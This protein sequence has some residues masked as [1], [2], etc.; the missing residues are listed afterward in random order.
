MP[1][2][3][4]SDLGRP[5]P[6]SPHAVS[7]CLP[8]WADNIGYE[9]GEPRV[10]DKLTTGYP[11]FVYNQFCRDLFSRTGE[12]TCDPGEQCLV[13]PTAAAAER[14]ATFL[15]RHAG[16]G[17]LRTL[18]LQE[19]CPGVPGHDDVHV[20]VF[21]A[22]HARVAQDAWQHIGEG[23]SSRQA[24]D[25]LAGRPADDGRQAIQT[26]LARVG[27]LAGVPET[28]VRLA[29]SGMG[30]FAAVH[31]ALDRLAPGADSVQFGFPYVDALKV[32]QLC[33]SA[34]NLFLPEGNAT[35]LDQL[36]SALESGRRFCGV[37]TEFPS[38]P[39]LAVPDLE[40]LAGLCRTHGI[41]LVVDET[42]SGFGN[43]DVLSATDVV[44][45][46]LTKSFSGIGDVT[47]GSS[48]VNPASPFAAALVGALAESPSPEPYA[49]DAIV[50]EHN[51]RDYTD[52]FPLANKNA[53][54]LVDFLRAEPGVDCVYYPDDENPSGDGLHTKRYD[55]FRRPGGGCG[56]LL[57]ILLE[58]P[59][60]TAP[61]FY[62][63]LAVD[64]GPNLGTNYTLAC[65]FTILAHYHE[66]AFAESCGVSRY[67]IRVSVGLEPV[68]DLIE[69][70][71]KA[72]Q[73][74]CR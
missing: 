4:P 64:K 57:S 66:L 34:D 56:P 28:H 9:E 18:P 7:A 49:T 12:T 8:T 13:F 36:Q 47:A 51:S 24:E 71:G 26:L 19:T 5:I 17:S 60:V 48:I 40:R 35:G 46:S 44:C 62:D 23:I 50:L 59:H 10:K 42:I 25:L 54:A 52:R 72:L 55:A 58:R 6:D 37:F 45:S 68:D 74:A 21:P 39:L 29:S 27:K 43:V 53:R 63:T 70:F 22:E 14:A 33:G 20:V 73:T 65:P 69:I 41:P 11:R 1:L 15:S 16:T 38:N 31:R 30:A 32:Q 3:Q 61:V 67:L 2:C